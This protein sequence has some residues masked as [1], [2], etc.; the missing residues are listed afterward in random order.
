[1]S[2]FGS[3]WP[4]A[5]SLSVSFPSDQADIGHYDNSLRQVFDQVADRREWQ[6]ATLRAFQ[7]WAVKANLN[8]GLVADRGDDFGTTGLASNDP[9]FGE[10]RLARFLKRESSPMQR[11]SNR[12]AGTWSGDILLN[13]QVNYFLGKWFDGVLPAVP[14]A[15][16]KGPAVELFSVMLHEA[17]NAL[18]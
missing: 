13:T 10:F 4:D 11:P 16:E 15:N 17:G 7:T 5:R 2:T 14:A 6:E 8:I 9:R 18:A 3:A 1:M 12:G